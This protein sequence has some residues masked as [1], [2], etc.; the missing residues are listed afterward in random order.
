M[1]LPSSGKQN[2]HFFLMSSTP[3]IARKVIENIRQSKRIKSCQFLLNIPVLNYYTVLRS[4]L[5]GQMTGAFDGVE[6]EHRC[7][8][9]NGLS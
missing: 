8:S 6:T 9:L 1:I 7:K 3:V 5:S 4:T 2:G